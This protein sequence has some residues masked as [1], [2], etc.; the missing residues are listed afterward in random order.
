MDN[1]FKRKM[2]L[3]QEGNN[4]VLL[5]AILGTVFCLFIFLRVGFYLSG[6]PLDQYRENIFSWFTLPADLSTLAK[7]PW[8]L[9][10]YMFMHDG[11]WHMLGNVIWIWIFGYILQDLAGP[12]KIIP[13]FLYGGLAGG[14][15]FLISYNV[16]PGLRVNMPITTVEGASAGAMA[17]AIATTVLA[18][19]YRIF[20]MINGGIPLWVITL[21]YIIVDVAM[22]SSSNS[23]GHIAH[24]GGA[25]M[26]Y[27][28]VLQLKKG[29]DWSMPINKFF[30]WVS[31]LFNP[32]KKNWKKTA[33]RDFHYS[34]KGT[35]PFK[36][37][38]NI[39]Q[40]RID[41]I[42]DKINQQGY[43]YLTEEEKDILKRAAD[44]DA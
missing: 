12:T 9:I 2:T 25:L 17:I 28:F 41:D 19:G 37:I 11:V 27:I 39:T 33:K 42:L 3:G 32:D 5:L 26:G 31:N 34:V 16:F 30:F 7:R 21:I 18:P 43:R 44:D 20:P 29:N 14:I 15:L 6:I 23:G 24:I 36:K 8:T 22:I 38:P 4:L 10:T 13:I 35:E 40:K 1:R